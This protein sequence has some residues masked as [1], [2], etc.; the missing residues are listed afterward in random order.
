VLQGMVGLKE[1]TL[2]LNTEAF[3]C[4]LLSMTD[5]QE[6]SIKECMKYLPSDTGF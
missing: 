4:F 2:Y 5:W 3:R 6:H 1:H